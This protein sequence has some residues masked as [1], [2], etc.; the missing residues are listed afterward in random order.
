MYLTLQ[1]GERALCV[2]LILFC[3]L[4]LFPTIPSC[5]SSCAMQSSSASLIFL[6]RCPWLPLQGRGAVGM[7]AETFHHYPCCSHCSE[8][9][10]IQACPASIAPEKCI[11][12]LWDVALQLKVLFW[13]FEK[14]V[15]KNLQS[16]R[17]SGL[18]ILS[19]FTLHAGFGAAGC[20]AWRRG[21]SQRT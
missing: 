4:F 14:G 10:L 5:V 11:S 3:T 6:W 8:G 9:M 1:P 20:C 19:P 16:V 15:S 2:S 17:E 13:S 12:V 7:P 21:F 18:E